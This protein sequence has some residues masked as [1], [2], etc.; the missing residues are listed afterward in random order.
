MMANRTLCWSSTLS[1]WTEQPAVHSSAAG[2]WS[3]FGPVS[4]MTIV[5]AGRTDFFTVVVQGA[6]AIVRNKMDALFAAAALIP[7]LAQAP[8]QTA[9][10]GEWQSGFDGKSL[11]GWKET[12]FTNHGP[13]RV[14]NGAIV[15]G[16]G[17]PM[18]GFSPLRNRLNQTRA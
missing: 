7:L 17:S 3:I 9:K 14:E 12:P 18:T 8:P 1:T 15:L 16:A 11:A 5:S 4:V 10:P 6:Y 2:Q 13:V